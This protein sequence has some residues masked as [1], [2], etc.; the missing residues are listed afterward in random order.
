[1]EKKPEIN[2]EIAPVFTYYFKRSAVS[3]LN[4]L[5]DGAWTAVGLVMILWILDL[6]ESFVKHNNV[7]G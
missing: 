4:R 2:F 3:V 7:L 6:I 1:M 5:W